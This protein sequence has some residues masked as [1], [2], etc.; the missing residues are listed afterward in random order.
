MTEEAPQYPCPCCGYVTLTEGPGDYEICPNCY[1]ED[2]LSQLR[3]PTTR[4]ANHV[5]LIEA[6][7]NYAAT[8]V[9]EERLAKYVR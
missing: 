1:W 7:K 6:Q 5:S 9:S 4:G 2:D 8:G 3:F